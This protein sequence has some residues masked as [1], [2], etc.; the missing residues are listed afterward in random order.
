MTSILISVAIAVLGA[1][2]CY[3]FGRYLDGT[4][5]SALGGAL[6]V[7][8]AI[9][10]LLGVARA[11][12]TWWRG[13]PT[14][15]ADEVVPTVVAASD[16]DREQE[17]CIA[18]VEATRTSGDA[19]LRSPRT[20]RS[21]CACTARAWGRGRAAD[22][23]LE[24]DYSTR[25]PELVYEGPG[26]GAFV[27]EFVSCSAS[28]VGS[29]LSNECA[30]EC[31]SSAGCESFCACVGREASRDARM[32]EVLASF[33]APPAQQRGLDPLEMLMQGAI[34]QCQQR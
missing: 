28:A 25:F 34:T 31:E 17:R 26:R 7:A 5:Q 32:R 3:G 23:A 8:G 30:M 14:A 24:L 18:H 2:A 21:F 1:A 33:W 11:G 10:L 27:E 16:L 9:V 19:E 6:R 15:Q 4:G 29:W 22:G 12:W 13:A 20:I